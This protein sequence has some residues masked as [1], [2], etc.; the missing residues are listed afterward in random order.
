MQKP[1]LSPR[2]NAA[3][4]SE[5]QLRQNSWIVA[6]FAAHKKL[7]AKK[8]ENLPRRST[9]DDQSYTDGQKKLSD[10][11]KTE[12]H[13]LIGSSNHSSPPMVYHTEAGA[14]VLTATTLAATA[15]AF[16]DAKAADVSDSLGMSDFDCYYKIH[17]TLSTTCNKQTSRSDICQPYS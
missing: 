2:S 12:D 7:E 15:T 5:Q 14:P 3:M 11:E 4:R 8:R 6:C 10:L 16:N 13:V 17:R 9:I 1:P